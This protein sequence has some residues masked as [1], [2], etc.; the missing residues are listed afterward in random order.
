MTGWRAQL[1]AADA[2][3]IAAP[4]YAGALAG[5]VKNALDWL[6]GSGELYGKPIA[7]LSAGTTGGVLARRDLVR[8]LCWQG[9][10]VVASAGI[11]APKAKSE[12]LADGSRR[13]T[14]AATLAEIEA[15][16]ASL[17][18]SIA[19]LPVERLPAMQRLAVDAGIDPAPLAE[20]VGGRSTALRERGELVDEVSAVT[21]SDEPR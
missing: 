20:R 13:F 1:R 12:A 3:L 21:A 7:L 5:V 2:V 17:V 15:V 19:Q 10:H 11:V 16:V 4:E 9:A 18:A 6:V 14:D 8:T